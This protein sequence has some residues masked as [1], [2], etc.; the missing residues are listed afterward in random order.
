MTK[1]KRIF[2]VGHSGAGK[3]VL[4]QGIAEK[5]GWKFLD[6]DFALAVSIGRDLDEIIGLDGVDVF[7]RILNQILSHQLTQE[8]IVVTTG[9][10][11]IATD[12]NR[13]ILSSEFTVYLKVSTA[14]QM[15]RISHNRPLLPI[16]DYKAF[17]DEFHHK[18]DKLFEQVASL[19]L[20]SDENAL[21]EHVMKV[22]KSIENNAG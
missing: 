15:Q 2:I 10:D 16:G 19:T 18:N 4:A 17:L 3:G 13:K 6:A 5:L 11:I 1:P 7:H 20:N 21:E 14:V 12:Q 9:D 22:V 8:N